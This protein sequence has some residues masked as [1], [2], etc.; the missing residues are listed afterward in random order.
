MASVA[1][2][3]PDLYTFELS[4]RPDGKINVWG[5][6]PVYFDATRAD[7]STFKQETYEWIVVAVEQT[8]AH[9]MNKIP[10]LKADFY[11]RRA[12]HVGA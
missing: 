5:Y 12:N 10:E 3:Q 1:V 9:G 11:K 6:V 2:K 8:W 7:G 4:K